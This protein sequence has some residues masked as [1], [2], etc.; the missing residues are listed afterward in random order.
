M[1]QR[2]CRDKATFFFQTYETG[3]ETDIVS[4][5]VCLWRQQPELDFL[6]GPIGV[7]GGFESVHFYA[8]RDEADN[9][10]LRIE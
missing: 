3:D 2:V 8:S 7:A 6:G 10:E 9:A 4:K 5:T 1:L